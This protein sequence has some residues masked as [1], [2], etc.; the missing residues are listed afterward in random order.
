MKTYVMTAVAVCLCLTVQVSGLNFSQVQIESTVGSGA[1]E[2]MIVFDWKSGTT[3]S[4]AWL[5]QWDG[6]AVVAD[7]YNA[8]QLATPTFSWSQAAFVTELDYNDGSELH[9][10]NG[11]GWMSFWNSGDGESWNTNNFS[12]FDQP[13]IDG[14]W[15]GANPEVSPPNWSWPGPAPTVPLVPEPA[16]IGLLLGG[17]TLLRSR[18]LRGV[19]S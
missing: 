1:N 13:L 15:S 11:D 3:P 6:T 9:L 14:D 5:F 12:V 19:K 18:R 16:S 2:A 17:V 8:I 4:H 10:G 7:A